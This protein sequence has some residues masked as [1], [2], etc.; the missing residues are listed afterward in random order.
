MDIEEIFWGLIEYYNV[1][2]LIFYNFFNPFM[3][4]WSIQFLI[5]II[6]FI[7]MFSYASIYGI[8]EFVSFTY[9]LLFYCVI[10]II[11]IIIIIIIIVL[12]SIF[13][14]VD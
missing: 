9:S 5:F 6:S 10:V 8:L 14:N 2:V 11:I 13:L 7:F 1:K 12:L 3:F 4:W